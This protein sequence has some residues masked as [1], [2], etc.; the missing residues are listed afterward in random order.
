MLL[1]ERNNDIMSVYSSLIG[2][3][4]R[5]RGGP[6]RQS[7]PAT[8]LFFQRCRGFWTVGHAIS[9]ICVDSTEVSNNVVTL[10]GGILFWI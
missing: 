4:R 9:V 7:M 5:D 1:Q 3:F 8:S 2:A 6:M 10:C